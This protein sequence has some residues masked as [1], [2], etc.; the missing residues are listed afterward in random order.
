[1]ITTRRLWL[2]SIAP[3]LFACTT[4]GPD[5]K[6]PDTA[7]IRSPQAQGAFTSG[8]NTAL[9][10]APVPDKWWQLYEDERLNALVQRALEANTDIRVAMA[11]LRR[12]VASY[13]EVEA[14]NLIQGGFHGTTFRAKLPSNHPASCLQYRGL[15]IRGVISHR[16]VR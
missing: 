2:A 5:Y 14:E 3:L 15:W 9:S 4:V 11:N 13:H 12:A 10:V 8:D 16:S 1:M 6:V 7:I